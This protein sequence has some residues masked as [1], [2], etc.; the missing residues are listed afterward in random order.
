MGCHDSPVTPNT[1]LPGVVVLLLMAKIM[2]THTHSLICMYGRLRTIYIRRAWSTQR[3]LGK[4]AFPIYIP[5]CQR[6]YMRLKIRL[7]KIM[8]TWFKIDFVELSYALLFV[9]A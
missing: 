5:T 2:H 8:P 3:P 6:E 4:T 7:N 9:L 1:P